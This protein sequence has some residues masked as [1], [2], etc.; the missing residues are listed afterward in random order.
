[1]LCE[2]DPSFNED[3]TETRAELLLE[4]PVITAS[5]GIS[6]LLEILQG[7]LKHDSDV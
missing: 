5:S 6:L 2:R 7:Q 3:M 1:M 4:K